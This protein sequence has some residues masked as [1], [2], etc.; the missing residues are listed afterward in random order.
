MIKINKVNKYF[1][2]FKKNSNHVINNTTLTLEDKGLVALL[3][4]SGSGKTTLLNAIGGLDKINSGSI[5][6]DNKKITSHFSSKVDKIRNL[7]IGYI[8][9][10]YKLVDNMSVFDNVALSLKTIGIKDKKEINERVTYVLECVGMYRYRKR[11]ASMLSGGERQRVGIARAI[12][13][14]PHIIIADEPTGN[15]DSKNSLEIMNIIKKISE[16]RLVVLVT[17]EVGLAKF[18]ASRIIEIEDGKIISDE[19]NEHNED[20]DYTIDNNIYL[21]DMKIKEKQDKSG[22]DIY[23][24][25]NQKL[26]IEIVLKGNNIYIKSKNNKKIEV[27]DETSSIEFIDDHFKTMEKK[28]LEKIEFNLSE[29]LTN[30]KKL[31]YTSIFNPLTFISNGFN[32]VFDY[33][34][35]KKILLLGFFAS[36]FFIM[37]SLSR[38]VATNTINDEDFV[39]I[40]K[41]YLNVNIAKYNPDEYMKYAAVDG[42]NYILPGNSTVTFRLKVDDYYQTASSYAALKGSLSSLDMIT[43]DEIVLGRMPENEF[44]IVVDDMIIRNAKKEYEGLNFMGLDTKEKFIDRIATINEMK[45]YKIVGI[46][47]LHS[48][49]IY[50]NKSNFVNIIHNSQEESMEEDPFQS[51]NLFLDRIYMREGRLP[52]NDYEM[53]VNISDK[54]E[55]PINKETTK[56]INDRKMKVVG[57]YD[58]A[59]NIR[60]YLVNDNMINYLIITAG[61]N[62]VVSAYDKEKVIAS[63]QEL[64]LDIRDSYENSKEQYK[65]S[66]ESTTKATLIS[67]LVVLVISLIEIILMLRSSFLSRIKEVGIYRAIGLKKKDIYIMFSGEIIAIT[68]LAAIPGILLSAYVFKTIS[69]IS[70]LSREFIVNPIIILTA[71]II[72]FVFNLFFGLL[73]VMNTLRKRPAQI[74]ARTDI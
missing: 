72:V 20:L 47:D 24:D 4:P 67:S 56:T 49:S 48:P 35:I 2:R 21:K 53:I 5:Y 55:F 43:K 60:K 70:F 30:K 27:V 39:T 8:F 31:R 42:V 40:N 68:T 57:Y 69:T 52:G 1:N 63:Y 50:V 44:E 71:I 25:T 37:F 10:D 6:I 29:K 17:H 73:P 14:N 12:V 7:N 41:N 36:G 54:D 28:D 34:F 46:T 15:L 18:Y 11:P 19:I 22:I 26:D 61:K 32:K 58:S 64:G 33:S 13:K 45:D 16:D 65:K 59:Y 38:I 66:R 23:K 74:L 51:Y 9:Q 3:G 62:L